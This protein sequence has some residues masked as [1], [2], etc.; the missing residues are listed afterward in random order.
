MEPSDDWYDLETLN[1]I[2]EIATLEA[3]KY[4]MMTFL[5]QLVILMI[6]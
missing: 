5:K 4:R 2:A 3:W 1:S 6:P